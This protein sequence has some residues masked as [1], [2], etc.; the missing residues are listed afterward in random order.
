MS[1]FSSEIVK[2]ELRQIQ[3]LYHSLSARMPKYPEYSPEERIEFI[4][5]LNRLL[6]KQE[7][8]YTRVFLS[9]DEDS[10]EIKQN[11]RIA[12]KQMGIPPNLLGSQIFKKAK[13]SIENLR[14]HVYFDVDKT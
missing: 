14:K 1:L 11:F 9:D 13:E 4:D 6:D 10:E 3:E 7:I 5:D 12:A 2:G 8:L